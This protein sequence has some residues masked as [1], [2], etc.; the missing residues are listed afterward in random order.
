M[1]VSTIL[2]SA[3]ALFC[4]VLS[5]FHGGI[6][7]IANAQSFSFQSEKLSSS[8][9]KP[10]TNGKVD[11]ATGALVL[12]A[13]SGYA[14]AFYRTPVNVYNT[15]ARSVQ[16]FSAFFTLSS[17][18]T[19][20]NG[21]VAFVM[22]ANPGATPNLTDARKTFTVEFDA[23]CSQGS[24]G[25]G[26]PMLGRGWGGHWRGGFGGFGGFG[27]AEYVN[28]TGVSANVTGGYGWG[29]DNQQE[30][31][32]YFCSQQMP[33]DIDNPTFQYQVALEYNS[34]TQAVSVGSPSCGGGFVRTTVFDVRDLSDVI[35]GPVYI[36]F[37]VT[38]GGVFN[39]SQWN[40]TG[41]TNSS[42]VLSLAYLIPSN[43]V[44]GDGT[45]N[46]GGRYH[47]GGGGLAKGYIILIAVGGSAVAIAAAVACVCCLCVVRRRRSLKPT[48]KSV[49]KNVRSSGSIPESAVVFDAVKTHTV[50]RDT[51]PLN[52]HPNSVS[53]TQT[54]SWLQPIAPR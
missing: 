16:S 36:G 2:L 35:T 48:T 33:E 51:A 34:S 40:F 24:Y 20:G 15:A 30:E 17:N 49:A 44:N 8:D 7:A 37:I 46:F 18:A 21:T 27:V 10:L 50:H 25:G 28:N 53:S 43:D 41:N 38:G 1:K 29:W 31:G 4:I 9:L 45:G 22:V 47:H 3:I 42:S 23:T 32:P 12:D 11:S 5:G 54:A 52:P 26:G 14:Q 19:S 13:T 39:F 6:C